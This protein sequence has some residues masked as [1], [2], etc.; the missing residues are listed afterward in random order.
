MSAK[1]EQLLAKGEKYLAEKSFFG[2]ATPKYDDAM[3]VFQQAG[4]FRFIQVNY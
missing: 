2:K 4:S 3:E 1:A